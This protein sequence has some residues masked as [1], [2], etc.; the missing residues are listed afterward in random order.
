MKKLLSCAFALAMGATLVAG[1]AACAK[2]NNKDADLAKQAIETVK[3]TYSSKDAETIVNYDVLG[4]VRLEDKNYAVTWKLTS[5]NTNIGDF[6]SIGSLNPSTKTY[7]VS[8]SLGEVKVDY[9]MTASVTVGK[10]TESVSFN[11]NVPVGGTMFK[12]SEAITAGN[13]LESGA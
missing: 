4:Q 1:L 6:V 5:T 12:A 8:V 13:K 9:T 2:D 7:P 10:K 11:W 3:E